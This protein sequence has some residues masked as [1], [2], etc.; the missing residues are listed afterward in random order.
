MGK[1]QEQIA[2]DVFPVPSGKPKRA[3]KRA[4]ARHNRRWA[5]RLPD[6]APRRHFYKGW[7]W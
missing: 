3:C 7:Y 6:E 2:R 4:M 5:K 1:G